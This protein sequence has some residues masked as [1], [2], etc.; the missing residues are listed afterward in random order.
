[1]HL[2]C[3]SNGSQAQSETA[4]NFFE[5]MENSREIASAPIRLSQPFSFAHQT[6][7]NQNYIQ[8]NRME[9]EHD[10]TSSPIFPYHTMPS[11]P[12]LS[13]SMLGPQRIEAENE[14]ERMNHS[15]PS[16]KKSSKMEI[17]GEE[18]IV[19]NPSSVGQSQNKNFHINPHPI[20]QNDSPDFCNRA[21]QTPKTPVN[22][23]NNPPFANTNPNRNFPEVSLPKMPFSDAK[24]EQKKFESN[25]KI[26]PF[27]VKD[28]RAFPSVPAFNF[29]MK[30]NLFSLP[31]INIDSKP[32]Q[33]SNQNNFNFNL[34]S[35]AVPK[36]N[37]I[38]SPIFEAPKITF[39]PRK[40]TES[41]SNVTEK[42]PLNLDS[43]PAPKPFNLIK[44]P[45]PI[46]VSFNPEPPTIKINNPSTELNPMGSKAKIQVQ[47][48]PSMFTPKPFI[49]EKEKM[50][51][52]KIVI[53][54]KN[55]HS[56]FDHRQPN[57][58]EVE[59]SR[60]KNVMMSKISSI[61]D[62][63]SRLMNGEKELKKTLIA[64]QLKSQFFDQ[65]LRQL[66]LSSN[67]SAN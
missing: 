37:P 31:Q 48:M 28:S 8:P 35:I 64:M 3:D 10:N 45:P 7:G 32:Q 33:F 11:L 19:E 49:V 47:P 12:T 55:P 26:D 4:M 1:M 46:K 58:Y 41:S 67:I 2:F 36:I 15:S 18:G 56:P 39:G 62:R 54:V 61:K 20:L 14:G 57:H 13:P 42:K 44:L 22:E 38:P 16:I 51:P 65:K 29:E 53:E 43:I 9:I 27:V 50:N 25:L 40:S 60:E 63:I 17:E 52:S 66:E 6:L 34:P 30:P 24:T 23:I 59:L 5:D 21:N